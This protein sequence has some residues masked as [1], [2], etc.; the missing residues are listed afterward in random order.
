MLRGDAQ[1]GDDAAAHGVPVAEHRPAQVAVVER[2]EEI[3]IEN[4]Q[5][6]P[7]FAERGPHGLLP[8]AGL[9]HVGIRNAVG[10]DQPVV[11][12]IPVR[13]VVGVPVAAVAV[14]HG[15]VFTRF[16]QRLVHE[17]PDEPA[18]IMRI[19]ADQ[20]PVFAESAQ[21]IA[22][23]MRVFALDQRFSGIVPEVF[24][25]L[26]VVPVH[27]ADD[28][29]VAAAVVVD[30]TFVMDRPRGVVS[31]DPVVAGVEIGA[32]ARLVA[33]RPDDDRRVVDIAPHVA[34][35]AFQMRLGVGG[36]LGQRL[37][38]V[39]HAVRFEVGLG[40]QVEPVAVAERVPAGVVRVV[41]CAHGVEIVLLEDADVLDHPLFRDDISAVGVHFVA[42]GAFD[43]HGL[44]VH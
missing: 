20:R 43:K 7:V 39:A 14:D 11:A 21:R 30:R 13:S 33:Q 8:V 4:R 44:S 2:P 29:G 31:L 42:V 35:V 3:F 12:E 28:V 15:A 36:I 27:R 40:H 10:R 5:R 26:A 38:V 22:H 41:A 19:L 16:A 17:V 1:V 24:F 25:A 32:V 6:A 18:L 23:R 37:F 34:D 9:V